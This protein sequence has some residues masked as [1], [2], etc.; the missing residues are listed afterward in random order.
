[1]RQQT[2]KKPKAPFRIVKLPADRAQKV[3]AT[4]FLACN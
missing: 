2:A 3:E 4:S 1:M